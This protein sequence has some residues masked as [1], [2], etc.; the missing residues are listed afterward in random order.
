[1]PYNVLLLPLLG[2]YFF[3]TWSN[4]TKFSV[5]R[6]SGHALI[7]HSALAG[8]CLLIVSYLLVGTVSW[9]RPDWAIWWDSLVPFPYLGTS[10]TALLLGI[11]LPSVLNRLGSSEAAAIKAIEQSNDYL[12]MLLVRAQRE[13]KLVSITLKNRKAYVGFV[14]RTMDPMFDRKYIQLLPFKSGYRDT[15]TL[16]L[17]LAVD[18]TAVYAKLI[19]K[20]LPII[21]AGI[22]D[23]EIVIP[24][25]EI[26]SANLF[27][28]HAYNLFNPDVT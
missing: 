24:V 10:L 19:R 6:H 8:I 25:T 26:Q 3:L 9:Q 21:T 14:T 20:E 12:E 17:T 16:S 5:K 27:E 18:Y 28:P 22:Q 1:L 7:F 4:R 23:F 13:T 11:A 2:G 15:T